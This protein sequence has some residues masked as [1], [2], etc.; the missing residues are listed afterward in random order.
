M[1][2]LRRRL[3]EDAHGGLFFESAVSRASTTWRTAWVPGLR[4][5]VQ[6]S[7]ESMNQ[8]SI[9]SE[10]GRAGMLPHSVATGAGIIV[11]PTTGVTRGGM[12]S[13]SFSSS[14]V[15][16][17]FPPTREPRHLSVYP[18]PSLCPGRC[19]PYRI[20]T[21][22]RGATKCLNANPL[23]CQLLM[24]QK[25]EQLASERIGVQ[26]LE[27][28]WPQ[29]W[30]KEVSSWANTFRQAG[31]DNA[32]VTWFTRR[33]EGAWNKEELLKL[34]DDMQPPRVT[35]VVA[36]TMMPAPVATEWGSIPGHVPVSP[37]ADGL[38]SRLS[39]TM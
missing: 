28:Y 15:P 31:W 19:S 23:R 1:F 10:L 32:K 13:T 11:G 7:R 17:A 39:W 30:R 18:H 35:P 2:G 34:V 8:V 22:Q 24:A 3:S 36:R 37:Y 4:Y 33:A 20:F 9:W 27:K 38:L 5:I 16:D 14:S 29:V 6:L 26:A 12:S 21:L 25:G